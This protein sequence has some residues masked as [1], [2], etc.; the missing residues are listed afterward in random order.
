MLGFIW[1]NRTHRSIYYWIKYIYAKIWV[2]F[3]LIVNH[4][5]P[6]IYSEFSLLALN[7]STFQTIPNNLNSY[8]FNTFKWASDRAKNESFDFHSIAWKIEGTGAIFP[9]WHTKTKS[10][11]FNRSQFN[12]I[13]SEHDTK[14]FIHETKHSFAKLYLKFCISYTQYVRPYYVL[15]VVLIR[16]LPHL[17]GNHGD[18]I[19]ILYFDLCFHCMD[20]ARHTGEFQVYTRRWIV[21]AIFTMYSA[22]NALQWIQYSIIANVVER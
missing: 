9:W 15:V 13:N 1:L 2:S 6:L 3:S 16:L 22:S 12:P 20:G 5:Q 19:C 17:F 11:L 8:E 7:L 14:F 4:F 18:I 10:H 21:L